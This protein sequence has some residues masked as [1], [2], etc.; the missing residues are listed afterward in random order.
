MRPL[1]SFAA[2]FLVKTCPARAR[3]LALLASAQ[4][5]GISTLV[6]SENLDLS[7]VLWK[8]SPAAPAGGSTKSCKGWQSSDMKRYRFRSARL[9]SVLR[10]F[11]DGCLSWAGK[12]PQRMQLSRRGLLPTP[13]ASDADHGGAN[14][15]QRGK[16]T[17]YAMA[18]DTMDSSGHTIYLNPEFLYWMMGFPGN[19][20]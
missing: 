13:R 3:A 17:L 15:K 4:D 16:P 12:L 11:D 2:V 6:S 9:M 10:I 20:K 7:G 8:T 14:Q 1:I 5:S 19:L 18:V